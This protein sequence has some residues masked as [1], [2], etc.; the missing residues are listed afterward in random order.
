MP[1]TVRSYLVMGAALVGAGAIVATPIT[2]PQLLS[3][4]ASL[5]SAFVATV[6]GCTQ[7]DT[8]GLC[9]AP[10]PASSTAHPLSPP[11]S[12]DIFDLP[13]NLIIA[14]VNTPFKLFTALGEGKL[15]R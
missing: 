11:D 7:D 9:N 12:S 6:E 5:D 1:T 3:R 10:I 14:L 8:G 15:G 13:T 4:T 2:M